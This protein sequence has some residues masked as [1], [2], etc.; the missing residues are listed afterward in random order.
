M[1]MGGVVYDDIKHE[2]HVSLCH[3]LAQPSKVFEAAKAR[4]HRA[5]VRHCVAAVTFAGRT[6]EKWHEV[7]EVDPELAKVVQLRFHL[8]QPAAEAVDVEAH[9]RDAV[10]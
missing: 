10:A 8:G 3:A 7:Q 6:L 4:V 2:K 9:A 1:V 5:V